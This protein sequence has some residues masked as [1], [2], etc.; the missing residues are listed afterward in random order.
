VDAATL[1]TGFLRPW[2]PTWRAGFSFPRQSLLGFRVVQMVDGKDTWRI[3]ELRAFDGS[4][5]LSRN[6]WMAS[7]HPFPW[8]IERAFDGNVVTFWNC[9]DPLRAGSS[10]EAEFPQSQTLDSVLLESSPNQPELRLELYGETA[11][12][13]WK[14]I[15]GAPDIFNGAAQELRRAAVLALKRRGIGYVLLFDTDQEAGAVREGAAVA[16]MLEVGR[17]DKATLYR[18]Q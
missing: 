3:H 11:P 7:A 5:E 13:V 12:G 9:G 16:G 17:A 4:K 8:G 15:T 1:W 14:R 6:G 10:V 2:M 18:L